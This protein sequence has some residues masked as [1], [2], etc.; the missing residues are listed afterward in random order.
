MEKYFTTFFENVRH[1]RSLIL[2]MS[3]VEPHIFK[4]SKFTNPEIDLIKNIAI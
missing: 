4:Q 1:E 2:M 3:L